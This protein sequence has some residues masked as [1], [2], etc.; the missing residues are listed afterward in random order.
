MIL[1][2]CLCFY[3]GPTGGSQ[4]MF[5][6]AQNVL[7]CVDSNNKFVAGLDEADVRDKG[8][9]KYSRMVGQ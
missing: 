2:F 6:R 9:D 5:A 7:E 3:L 1:C 8:N 4:L